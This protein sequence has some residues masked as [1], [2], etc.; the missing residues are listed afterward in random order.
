MCY[1]ITFGSKK[2]Y[3]LTNLNVKPQREKIM[4]LYECND[5][6]ELIYNN[7]A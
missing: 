7:E 4:L 3:A 2:T 1:K 5:V 6:F